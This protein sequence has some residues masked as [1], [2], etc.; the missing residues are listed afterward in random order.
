ME[1]KHTEENEEHGKEAGEC[2]SMKPEEKHTNSIRNAIF[3]GA[4][5]LGVA[6]VTA[7]A[8]ATADR[9]AANGAAGNKDKNSSIALEESVAPAGGVELPATWGDLGKKMLASGVID[10]AKF[11]AVYATRGGMSPDIKA[12]LTDSGNGKIRITRENSG[13]ILNLLWALGLG[14]KNDILDKGEMMDPRYKGPGQF[15]STGGWTLAQGGPMD[16]YSMHRFLTLDAAAQEKVDRVTK[17]IYR[18]CCGNST[19]FPDCNHGMAMLGL[20]ELMASQGASEA[21]MYRTA[22]Q[23]NAYWFPEQYLTIAKV[24]ASQGVAWDKADPRQILGA[25]YSSGAGFQQVAQTASQLAKPEG[26]N[27]RPASGGGCSV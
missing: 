19:H 25:D 9:P 27:A 26:D 14:N 23:V 21:D 24:L 8:I 12:M 17:N 16:H 15:A 2:C 11:E 13:S 1:H 18:P 3:G 7:T 6:I 5:V 10:Q 4:L 22:L 20:M